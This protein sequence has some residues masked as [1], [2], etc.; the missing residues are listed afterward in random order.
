VSV[1]T[2]LHDQISKAAENTEGW[3]E[4]LKGKLP[5]IA[6]AAAKYENSAIVQALEGAL[7][8]PAVEQQI[9]NLITE[10]GKLGAPTAPA[11]E[12]AAPAATDTPAPATA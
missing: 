10:L 1:L 4:E 11:N 12:P 8:P 3:I 6:D 2:E 9:A 7:L 5:A